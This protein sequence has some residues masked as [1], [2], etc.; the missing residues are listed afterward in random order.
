MPTTAALEF[1][2]ALRAGRLLR[3]YTLKQVSAATGIP[4]W[5]LTS[6]ERGDDAP[7]FEEFVTVWTFLCAERHGAERDGGKTQR[8]PRL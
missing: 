3:G 6:L 7:V 1:A 4:S 2:T 5:R 8:P